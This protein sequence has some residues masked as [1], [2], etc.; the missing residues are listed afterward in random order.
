MPSRL[1]GRVLIVDDEDLV[2]A[3]L[4]RILKR[5]GLDVFEAASAPEART[6][7]EHTPVDLV[8]LDDSMP[9]ESG[10]AAIPSL[11]ARTR[12]PFVLFTGHAPAVPEGIAAL[13]RKPARPDELLRVV[14]GL[15]PAAGKPSASS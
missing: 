7:L 13:V 2:R 3:T 1:S 14:H 9:Y 6:L 4:R 12:A 10:L 5:A 8:V 11:R 15:L